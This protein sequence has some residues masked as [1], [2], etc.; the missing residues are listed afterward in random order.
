MLQ[1][2]CVFLTYRVHVLG[3][4]TW[5][6]FNNASARSAI[7]CFLPERKR[8]PR[9][10]QALA[11]LGDRYTC[12]ARKSK[13]ATKTI[14]SL[15]EGRCTQYFR[16]DFRNDDVCFFVWV[17]EIEQF[18]LK[19]GRYFAL[20]SNQWWDLICLLQGAAIFYWASARYRST[21]LW[22]HWQALAGALALLYLPPVSISCSTIV[23][24]H[25]GSFV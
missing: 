25:C 8:S 19:V 4:F 17:N 18:K 3:T 1:V 20:I 14:T 2:I 13:M 21:I 24:K 11:I 9:C 5:G 22:S 6:V 15:R 23:S 10:L 7:E 16:F 12:I